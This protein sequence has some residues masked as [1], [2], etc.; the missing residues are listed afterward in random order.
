[1]AEEKRKGKFFVVATPIGN[2][3]DI[4]KRA[5]QVFSDEKN[6]FS[7]DTRNT[8]KLFSAFGIEKSGKK[9]ASL[10]QHSDKSNKLEQIRNILESGENVV[11]TTDAG[12]PNISDPG[13][14][15]ADL[16]NEGFEVV[17]IPGVSSL[18]AF[19]SSCGLSGQK[20]AFLGFLPKKGNLYKNFLELFKFVHTIIFFESP[21]RIKKVI[22]KLKRE[23]SN[24]DLNISV[25][26]EITK[27]HEKIIYSSL[28]NLDENKLSCKGEVIVGLSISKRRKTWQ[29]NLNF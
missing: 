25:G 8:L 27:I 11:Y 9:F 1:L 28:K 13:D 2:L 29:N 15:V 5:L 12:T 26:Y 16:L 19:L 4:T 22:S 18:T 21:R 6:F 3:K 14:F 17:P 10:H 7:E 20:F 24:I 23:F